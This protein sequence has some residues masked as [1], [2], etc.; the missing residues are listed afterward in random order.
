MLGASSRA[1]DLGRFALAWNLPP[2]AAEI[3]VDG[4]D[5]VR[6]DS[7]GTRLAVPRARWAT[8]AQAV[9]TTLAAEHERA[10]ESLG[11]S[12]EQ[13][14]RAACPS[15]DRPVFAR[16]V[17]ELCQG[18]ELARTGP[19]LH[20]PGHRVRLAPAEALLWDRIRP[21][22]LGEPFHPPRVRD[23]AHRL[24][25]DETMVRLTLRRAA[26]M[27]EAYQVAHDHFFLPSSVRRL[28]ALAREASDSQGGV[29]AAAFRDR[30]G[31][32]RK[33]AIQI[34]EFF[35]RVG[36]SR[37]VGDTHRIVQPELFA[38]PE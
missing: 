16:L 34:L 18:G 38:A 6:V 7:A 37:R 20:L 28:A 26:A 32:G 36:L 1:V 22:L 12:A 33:L 17:E 11:P 31:T 19:W 27:G 8:L 3:L 29:Q 13:L 4:L 2:G 14:R 10:P 35:D 24:G 30:I 25:V 23:M 9:L 5:A 21:L 15:L